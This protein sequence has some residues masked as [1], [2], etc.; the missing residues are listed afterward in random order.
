MGVWGSCGSP[1][2]RRPKAS[3]RP[4]DARIADLRSSLLAAAS[5]AAGNS[6]EAERA[7]L[8]SV[9]VAELDRARR[10]AAIGL[11]VQGDLALHVG[12][13]VDRRVLLLDLEVGAGA[14]RGAAVG[15]GG[16]HHDHAA[17]VDGLRGA[18]PA[19]VLGLDLD[20]GG[21]P[22]LARAAGVGH[23]G[24]AVD[25]RLARQLVA[26]GWQRDQREHDR[27]DPHPP[28]ARR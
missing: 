1:S 4:T 22:A 19:T 24:L 10:G 20:A 3:G 5:A 27:R 25:G 2:L 26:A 8:A 15:A 12:D 18:E 7:F 17:A 28:G 21:A 6:F 11:A 23:E 14:E 13:A 16:E 9:A